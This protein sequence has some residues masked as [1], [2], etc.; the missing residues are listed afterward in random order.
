VFAKKPELRYKDPARS[1]G[2][3]VIQANILN[4]AAAYVKVGGR[5]VYS[6]CTL[7]PQENEQNVERFLAE[8]PSFSLVRMR[9][10]T[11]L[12]DGTDGFFFAV[13]EK[14]GNA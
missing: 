3:P 1:E 14:S 4:T 5:L 13:L 7:L 10:L 6:T 12:E 8:H 9:T 2:L 11:P